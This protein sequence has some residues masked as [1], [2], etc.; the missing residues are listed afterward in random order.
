MELINKEYNIYI[1]IFISKCIFKIIHI[2]FNNINNTKNLNIK[3]IEIVF[4]PI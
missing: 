1:Y 4:F 3:N 2:D